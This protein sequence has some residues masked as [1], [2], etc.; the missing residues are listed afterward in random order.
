VIT[1]VYIFRHGE[2]DWNLQR[3][4]QGMTD[5]PLND[6]GREQALGLARNLKKLGIEI[7]LT[8]DLVRAAETARMAAVWTRAP[9]VVDPGLRETNLGIAEGLPIDDVKSTLGEKDL[10]RWMSI[11]PED[12]H[13]SFKNGE[14]KHDHR[15]RLFDAMESWLKRFQLKVA[16]VSTHGGAMRRILHHIRPDLTEPVLFPNCGLY[17]FEFDSKTGKWTHIES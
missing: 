4:L 1:T 10:E 6:T 13:F 12:A 14:S 7:I 9:I 5:I 3:R 15:V 17:K 8:S 16:A 2:T 11:K